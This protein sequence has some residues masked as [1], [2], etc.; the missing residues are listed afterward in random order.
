MDFKEK[1]PF[2]HS[3]LSDDETESLSPEQEA[4]KQREIWAH[5]RKLLIKARRYVE[6]ANLY[7]FSFLH[8]SDVLS[9]KFSRDCLKIRVDDG[10]AGNS[11]YAVNSL[12]GLGVQKKCIHDPMTI[13]VEGIRKITAYQQTSEDLAPIP[14]G[15]ILPK[16]KYYLYD[17]LSAISHTG[18]SIGFVFCVHGRDNIVL[19]IDAR[20]IRFEQKSKENF[21]SLFGVKNLDLF[22]AL[23]QAREN[24]TLGL[25]ADPV[26]KIITKLRPKLPAHYDVQDYFIQR[27]LEMRAQNAR[28]NGML[29]EAIELYRKLTPS[30]WN[31][32]LK[33]RAMATCLFEA[34]LFKEAVLYI[35]ALLGYDQDDIQAHF[36]LAQTWHR[37]GDTVDA[38]DELEKCLKLNPNFKPAI[39]FIARHKKIRECMEEAAEYDQDNILH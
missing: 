20:S 1:Y 5:D 18:I 22:D 3:F 26:I 17:E 37:L 15:D 21:I 7:L 31:P 12:L 4:E 29:D 23:W 28:N 36:L 27:T 38:A 30:H 11:F 13:L 34:K 24:R 32:H 25:D 33:W 39:Q 8:D 2:I 9:A 14:V 19:D 10:V 16:L 35:H 6:N